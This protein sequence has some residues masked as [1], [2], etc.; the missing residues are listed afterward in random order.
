MRQPIAT[1]MS[2]LLGGKKYG[3]IT[4]PGDPFVRPAR[5]RLIWAS[6]T[7][8]AVQNLGVDAILAASV[9]GLPHRFESMQGI[10]AVRRMIAEVYNVPATF[11]IRGLY[12]PP[13]RA[14]DIRPAQW[15][16]DYE[17]PRSVFP[18][19][20]VIHTRHPLILARALAAGLTGVYED[21]DED[22]NKGFDTL[23]ALV[24]AHPNLRVVIAIT[25]AVQDRLVAAGV[26]EGRT[27]ILDSGVNSQSFARHAAE[28]AAIRG[29]LLSRGFRHIIV[30]SGGL[31]AERG[32]EHLIGA[33]AALPDS[34][35]ILFGGNGGDQGFWR[36]RILARALSNILIPGYVP[37]RN[38]LA[39]HQAADVLVVSR[40]HDD[41]AAITSP[42]KFFE[43]LAAGCPVVAARLP[44]IERHHAEALA[45]TAYDPA[46]PE[47]MAQA[48]A[49]SCAR[50]PWKAEG[51]AANIE[52]ARAFT[53]EQRQ[54]ALFERLAG[55][56]PA[57]EARP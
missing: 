46:A 9:Q 43:Y 25:K 13:A 53:W 48:I 49:E 7:A 17:I 38:L 15:A 14:G 4:V 32:I 5:A 47:S 28:A 37:Q 39:F 52:A 19:C 36:Q 56:S 18:Y 10:A 57:T 31:Q 29:N 30:Y 20:G 22:H 1:A 42:L 54:L 21:H 41:R 44:A 51:H 11:D 27:M 23:P 45:L 12:D 34:L 3:V 26:P 55:L 35:F 24:A 2:R 50:H 16:L 40:Q 8:Q 33:A 6:N